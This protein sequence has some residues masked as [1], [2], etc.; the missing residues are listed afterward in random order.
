[1]C[2][3]AAPEGK[4]RLQE[5][6]C[7]VVRCGEVRRHRESCPT[8]QRAPRTLGTPSSPLEF[9]SLSF[10]EQIARAGETVVL[11]DQEPDKDSGFFPKNADVFIR[12]TFCEIN[13]RHSVD[14]TVRRSPGTPNSQ[15]DLVPSTL[16][17]ITPA[18]DLILYGVHPPRGQV[19]CVVFNFLCASF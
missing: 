7:E 3:R 9:A 13:E 14:P 6:E 19:C 12:E 2:V 15:D 1:M 17:L 5:A 8:L 16:Q 18:R 4:L 10:N 11:N